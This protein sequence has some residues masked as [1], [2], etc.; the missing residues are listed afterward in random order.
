MN[1]FFAECRRTPIYV[2]D[3]TAAL[4][5]SR[6]AYEFR[7]RR[8]RPEY[9]RT[10]IGRQTCTICKCP[11]RHNARACPRK[12]TSA[13]PVRKRTPYLCSFCKCPGHNATAC[14]RKSTSAP[15]CRG[16]HVFVGLCSTAVQRCSHPHTPG[17][18]PTSTVGSGVGYICGSS[19]SGVNLLSCPLPSV[20]ARDI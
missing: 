7:I 12:A 18:G 8:A 11:G 2:R 16:P 4:A 3:R 10:M 13:L 5:L 17:T 14:P 9:S 6:C 15:M 1:D 20:V 19:P